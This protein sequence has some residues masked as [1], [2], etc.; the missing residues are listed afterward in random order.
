MMTPTTT[1]L[2]LAAIVLPPAAESDKDKAPMTIQGWGEVVD[3]AGDCRIS[4][5]KDTLRIAVPGTKHD[6]NPD[7]GDMN[8]PQVLRA[9]E[10][11][12]IAQIKV[13]GNVRH[14]GRPLT[15]PFLPYHGAG[16]LLW[17]DSQT[18]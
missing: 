18:Y 12:F 6:L 14:A 1:V 9:I 4:V 5:D 11:D 17:V 8:A 10:G 16:L 13:S 15:A 3:P 2:F 7:A